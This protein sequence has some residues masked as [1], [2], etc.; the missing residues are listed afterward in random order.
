MVELRDEK[1]YLSKESNLQC[2]A[3]HQSVFVPAEKRGGVQS[4]S[5]LNYK[6][7]GIKSA[8]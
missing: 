8:E 3:S 7:V 6:T 1:C 4:S 2:M 5:K